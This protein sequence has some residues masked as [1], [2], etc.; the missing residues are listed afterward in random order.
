MALKFSLKSAYVSSVDPEHGKARPGKQREDAHGHGTCC[1]AVG[2]DW[3]PHELH[4][5]NHDLK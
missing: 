3:Q 2:K 4:R 5:S 1:G